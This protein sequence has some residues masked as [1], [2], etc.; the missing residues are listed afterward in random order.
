[1][2]SDTEIARVL[3]RHCEDPMSSFSIGSHGAI[4]EFHRDADEPLAIDEPER[5]TIGTRR[6]ALRVELTPGVRPLAYETLSARAGR[7][8]HGVVFCL[9]AGRAEGRRRAALTELGPDRAALRAADRNQ[10]LFDIGVGARN[11]DF[12]VRTRDPTL[13]ALLRRWT[14]RSVLEPHGPIMA[15]VVDASPHRVAIS[16]LGRIEVYQAIARTRTPQGPHTHLLPNLLA[17]GRTHSADIP[18]P[19]GTL[20]CLSLYPPSALFD[21][22]GREKPFDR[23]SLAAFETLLDRWGAPQYRAEKARV[24]AAV[25]AGRS[26]GTHNWPRSRLG[27]TALRVALR[28]MRH[29]DRN[30][31]LVLAWC[32]HFD[33]PRRR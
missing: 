5:L 22:L 31:P 19:R 18:V 26:P 15:A 7:W 9:A 21:S 12:C 24:V 2:S 1:M 4:A 27:R 30:D 17:G 8:Q 11:V 6:G 14:G 13:L 3:R 28:Q 16:K 29:R 20:P 10:I 25:Q 33:A 23:E 32:R